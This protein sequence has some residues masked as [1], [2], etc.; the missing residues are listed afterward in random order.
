MS[1]TPTKTCSAVGAA[2]GGCAVGGVGAWVTPLPS[3]HPFYEKIGKV[4]AGWAAIERRLDEM[5]FDLYQNLPQA[6]ISRRTRKLNGKKRVG[7]ITSSCELCG[8]DPSLAKDVDSLWKD[9][10]D[11]LY[12]QRN[13]IVHDAWYLTG[14]DKVAQSR[15]QL[16][17]KE[18]GFP[19]ITGEDL[20]ELKAEIWRRLENLRDLRTNLW[21]AL[22]NRPS[23]LTIEDL[24]KACQKPLRDRP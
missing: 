24:K 10:L 6:E 18:Y 22:K 21:E 17:E 7:V 1:K 9:E 8:L 2:V 5:I 13:R 19:E 23:Y 16:P 12:Q 20:D 15:P 11:K 14:A 3:E 4:I